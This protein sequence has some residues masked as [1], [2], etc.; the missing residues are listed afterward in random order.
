MLL[1]KDGV[2]L[3]QIGS[4][5]MRKILTDNEASL[6]LLQDDSVKKGRSQVLAAIF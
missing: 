6:I 4:V 5:E 1:E 2:F 3:S